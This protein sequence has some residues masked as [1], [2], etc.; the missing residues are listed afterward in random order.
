MEILKARLIIRGGIQTEGIDFSETFSL[1]VKMTT[2]RC[3]L[4]VA[5][6]MNWGLFQ[7]DVDN[8]FS[9]GDS[10]EEVYMKFPVRLTPPSSNH[11]CRLKK[12]LYGLRHASRQWYTKLN[13]TLNFKGFTHSLNDYSIFFKKTNS[14]IC[15]VAIYADDILL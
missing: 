5:V 12:S 15:I 10:E 11:V 14:F 2:I 7:L 1:V 4:S 8:A 9:H 3:I 6:K 13:S